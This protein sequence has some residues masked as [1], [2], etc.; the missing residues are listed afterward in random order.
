MLERFA[1]QLALVHFT[2]Y[3]LSGIG[4]CVNAQSVFIGTVTYT[5]QCGYFAKGFLNQ[6]AHAH[7]SDE[8]LVAEMSREC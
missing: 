5:L 8:H 4:A 1:C 3:S 7:N 6:K 2:P